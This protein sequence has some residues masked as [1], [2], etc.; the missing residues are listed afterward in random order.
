VQTGLLPGAGHFLAMDNAQV[1][2]ERMLHFL[3]S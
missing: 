1:V 3:N 2:N